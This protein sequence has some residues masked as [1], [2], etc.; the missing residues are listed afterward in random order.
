MLITRYVIMRTNRN[1]T[2]QRQKH[3]QQRKCKL[4]LTDNLP[5]DVQYKIYSMKHQIEFSPSLNY[6]EKL[7]YCYSRNKWLDLSCYKH[8]K[9]MLKPISYRKSIAL[10]LDYEE[11]AI[12]D[13]CDCQLNQLEKDI[14]AKVYLSTRCDNAI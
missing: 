7:K 9:T 6:I 2:K 10:I 1:S 3:R 13:I 12:F 11:D 8:V 14:N 5:C 4:S